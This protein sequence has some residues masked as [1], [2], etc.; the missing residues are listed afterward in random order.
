MAFKLSLVDADDKALDG[1]IT[2]Y[3]ERC[4]SSSER[5]Y[6]LNDMLEAARTQGYAPTERL[7]KDWVGHGLLDQATRRGRG[8]A[9]GI[10][11]TWPEKQLELWL[12]LLDKRP[13]VKR[14]ATL[15]NIPVS[16]WL[17]WGPDHV[18]LRQ[19][20]RALLTWACAYEHIPWR[21]AR[22]TA[23]QL[24]ERFVHEEAASVDRERL[25]D[26]IARAA[27]GEAF[28]ADVVL[29]LFQR[30]FDPK[31]SGRAIG[32]AWLHFNAE[33][34]TLITEV[35]IQA[36]AALREGKLTAEDFEWAGREYRI[37]SREYD[38]HMPSLA[39]DQE[40]SDV[41]LKHTSSGVVLPTT[42]EEIA[43]QACIE[44]L[45]ML[46]IR[47]RRTQGGGLDSLVRSP[48]PP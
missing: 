16:I 22:W 14:V 8:H 23:E 45:T 25:V 30:V 41:F 19:V 10:E 43:N 29:S 24:V 20:E 9:Q 39:A 44:L 32:P 6:T 31:G 27:Y 17:W 26:A 34:F 28:R 13:Q 15:C 5:R 42:F 35:R 36:I 2:V 12:L 38:A 48:D 47:L 7:F 40:A 11:R 4:M 33:S 18:P 46:G 21:R 1:T 3:N 37:G